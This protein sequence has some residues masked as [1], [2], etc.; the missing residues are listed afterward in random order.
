M[1]RCFFC[2]SAA[3]GLLA[4]YKTCAF[5]EH[6]HDHAADYIR[7]LLTARIFYQHRNLPLIKD[8]RPTTGR[9]AD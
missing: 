6:F 5:Y 2:V 7:T 4:Q 1:R 8:T 3:K 9:R